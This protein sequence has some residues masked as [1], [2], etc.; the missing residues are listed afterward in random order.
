MKRGLSFPLVCLA[1]VALLAACARPPRP[2]AEPPIRLTLWHAYG[3]DLGRQFESL[4]AEFNQAHPGI[5]VEP[6]YGGTLWTMRDK[7]LT[8]IAGDAGPDICQIDQFWCAELAEAQAIVRLGDL[9]AADP[10]FE[11]ADFYDKCWQTASYQGEVWTMPFS[12][13]NIALY[14]NKE[15]FAAAGLDPDRPPQTWSE[16]VAAARALTHDRDGDGAPEQWGLS[17]PLDAQSGNVYYWLAF[18][19]QNGGEL[20]DSG[21]DRSRFNEEPGV[22]ALQLWVDMVK[23]ERIVPVD[24]PEKGFEAGLIAMTFASTA[25]L[26]TYIEALGSERLG[27]ASLPAQER[28]ATGVGGANL[29]IMAAARDRQAAWTF[30]RWMTSP[31]VNLRWSM[32]TGYL[33]LR[34]SVVGSAEYQAYLQREPR[35]RLIVDQMEYGV[36]RPNIPAYAP[37]SREIG[38]AIEQ[39]VFGQEDP[40]RALDAAAAKVDLLL[41]K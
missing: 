41:R 2:A 12:L 31:E 1:I 8:A 22:E 4:V 29:A 24:P 25:R 15:L 10:S 40:Q 21:F 5:V 30:V 28:P 34:R 7:L 17:F 20:F 27:M 39:A 32:E 3:G 37:A 23:S 18:L 6:S 33:P 36:V 13:S 26:S 9:L 14:Y 11:P 16:L 35:A 38:L 19:W